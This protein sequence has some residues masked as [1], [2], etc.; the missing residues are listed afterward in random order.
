MSS[1]SSERRRRVLA[2]STDRLKVVKGEVKRTSTSSSGPSARERRQQRQRLVKLQRQQQGICGEIH[3]QKKISTEE[4]FKDSTI[5]ESTIDSLK[6][7]PRDELRLPQPG[8]QTDMFRNALCWFQSNSTGIICSSTAVLTGVLCSVFGGIP[9]GGLS[10]VI[11]LVLAIRLAVQYSQGSLSC[12]I[13]ALFGVTKNI[14]YDVELLLFW[15]VFSSC[16]LNL[17]HRVNPEFTQVGVHQ[18]VGAAFSSIFVFA[19]IAL[20]LMRRKSQVLVRDRTLVI[21]QAQLQHQ[22]LLHACG[23]RA[24]SNGSILTAQL[25]KHV[26]HNVA[27]HNVGKEAAAALFEHA[28]WSLSK[29]LGNIQDGIS[30]VWREGKAT[31]RSQKCEG[32]IR[33]RRL[34]LQRQRRNPK[35][36]TN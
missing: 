33:E 25:K 30:L 16:L 10:W 17:H 27:L 34:E 18:L 1:T 26:M 12:S 3:I 35:Q 11:I 13:T 28:I 5:L 2:A 8:P 23:A 19:A 21:V 22:Q 7:I 31:E 36:S 29:N 32:S 14:C 9:F 4:L 24:D 6:D 20:F 15:L